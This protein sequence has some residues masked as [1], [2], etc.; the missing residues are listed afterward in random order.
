MLT[1][2]KLQVELMASHGLPRFTYFMMF[3]QRCLSWVAPSF[4]TWAKEQSGLN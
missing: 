3:S 1:H 2:G 4:K